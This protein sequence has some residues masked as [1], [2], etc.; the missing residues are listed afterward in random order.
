MLW[1]VPQKLARGMGVGKQPDQK[2]LIILDQRA[3]T[4]NVMHH[5]LEHAKPQ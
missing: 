2:L 5:L 4:A 1:Q 3:L